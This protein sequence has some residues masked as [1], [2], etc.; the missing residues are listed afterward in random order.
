MGV[1]KAIMEDLHV[2]TVADNLDTINR[3]LLQIGETQLDA[4]TL[5]KML[6]QYQLLPRLT[7]R[8]IIED[9]IAGIDYDPEQIYRSFCER[10]ALSTVTDQNTWL[11]Q[12]QLTL[13]ELME[14]LVF[15][16][17]INR[18]KEDK[19]GHQ[20]E[21]YFLRRKSSLD[22]V[23]Y[24]FIRVQDAGIA[25]ELFFRIQDDGDNF[26]TLAR[27][28]SEGSESELG[29]KAGPVML[30]ECH[31]TIAQMLSVSQSGQLSAPTPIDYWMV[32]LRLDELIPAKL[33]GPMRHQLLDELFQTW[34]SKKCKESPLKI[35]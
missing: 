31:P 13:E 15:S 7:Q 9:A 25:Q 4:P 2:L 22:Q 5:V 24:S 23:R 1:R 28:Y 3:P 30:D 21:S 10:Q 32:I 26:D 8:L 11:E 20:V 33:G 18:F 35:L 12:N 27:Q 19:W 29:G 34:L 6:S 17:R 16:D 14:N